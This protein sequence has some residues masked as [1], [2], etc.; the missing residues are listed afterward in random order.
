MC[1]I[2]VALGVGVSANRAVVQGAGFA[3]RIGAAA[4]R[5]EPERSVALRRILARHTVVLLTQGV[6]RES[7]T[8]A[9]GA[10]QRKKLIRHARGQIHISNRR[11]LEAAACRC[12][13][14]DRDTWQRLLG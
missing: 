10:L 1:G 5:R 13:R 9:A 7:V 6:R 4:F 14:S 3:L 12:Y 11:G 2:V 8:Q